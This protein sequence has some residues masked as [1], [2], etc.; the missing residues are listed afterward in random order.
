MLNGEAQA[1]KFPGVK[2]VQGAAESGV[3][4]VRSG[5]Y[6]FVNENGTVTSADL[7]QSSSA[8]AENVFTN[9]LDKASQAETVVVELLPPKVGTA[10]TNEAAAQIASDVLS[11]SEKIK[12]VIFVRDGKVVVDKVK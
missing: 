3:K 1:G 12:R 9:I 5:D 11:T 10:I 8:R 7:L 2:E 4:G 6:R